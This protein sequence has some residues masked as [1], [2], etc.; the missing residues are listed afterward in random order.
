[1]LR[2]DI[3]KEYTKINADK[4]V[5]DNRIK[6]FNEALDKRIVILQKRAKVYTNNQINELIRCTRNKKYVIYKPFCG[7][8]SSKHPFRIVF[9]FLY[10]WKNFM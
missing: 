5:V 8:L 2:D 7:K 4:N 6:L 9:E 10:D 1:M 3:L